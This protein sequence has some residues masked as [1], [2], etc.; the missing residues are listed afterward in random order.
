[1]PDILHIAANLTHPISLAAFAI[2]IILLVLRLKKKVP[3]QFWIVIPILVVAPI[4]IS[5][6]I[7]MQKIKAEREKGQI[8]ANLI[9]SVNQSIYRVRATV[10]DPQ[11]IPVD[12]AKVWS[13]M[14][15]EPKRVAGGWQFDIPKASR[16]RD[17]K[18][19]I[20]ASL[21]NKFLKGSKELLLSD[22]YNPGVSIQLASESSA[23]VRGIIVDGRGRA[24]PGARVSVVGYESE[25]VVTQDG[26]SF[27]LPAHAATDQQVLLH[28]EKK[29]FAAM[30]QWHPAGDFPA[31]ITLE[32]K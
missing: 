7:E 17:G 21:P 22:D 23:S 29:G 31:T 30:Q 10:V 9:D 11:Q 24:I 6:S 4:I 19:T 28:A 12:D 26:G 27:V 15:G 5:A 8:N 20:Y 13:S 25:A 2:A 1:M 3:S 18:L 32:R 16:P 14:G